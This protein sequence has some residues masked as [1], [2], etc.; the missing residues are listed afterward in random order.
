[1]KRLF[2]F[3]GNLAACILENFS[4]LACWGLAYGEQPLCK[5]HSRRSK[6]SR[7]NHFFATFDKVSDEIKPP[8][9]PNLTQQQKT[10]NSAA[11]AQSLKLL[12]RF[13]VERVSFKEQSK[14]YSSLLVICH[15]TNE[16]N[17]EISRGVFQNCGVCG[18]AFPLLPP[19]SPSIFFGSRSDFRAIARLETL[20]TQA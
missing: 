10:R 18:Q 11:I 5:T 17:R 19:L 1:M 6:V 9:V 8:K 15:F 7:T 4:T 3:I 20:A 13:R 2:L 12:L 14:F 16:P